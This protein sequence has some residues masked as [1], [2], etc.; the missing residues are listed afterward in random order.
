MAN[1][2]ER[3]YDL[4]RKVEQ[5]QHKQ[6]EYSNELFQIRKEIIQLKSTLN[7]S[8]TTEP[9]IDKPKVA[10]VEKEIEPIVEVTNHSR[11]QVV[12]TQAVRK[13][14]VISSN[15]PRKSSDLE[16]FIGENLI[17]KIGILIVVIGVAIG[18]KYSI[19]HKLISPL[20]RIVLGYGTG[21]AL[22]LVGM[23]L[24]KNYEKYS[25]VLVSGAMAIMYF[26]TYAAY[27]IYI[28]M[29]QTM[30]FVLMLVFTVF[31]VVAA[32]NYKQQVIAHLGLVG[33][34]AVPFLLSDGSGRV[35]VLFTYIVII[36]M[37][38]L[39]VSF[40]NYWRSLYYASF[41]LTW[42][43]FLSWYILKYDTNLHL[44]ITVFFTLTTFVTFYF[45]F[46]AYKLIQ[47]EK[48]V[49]RDII[50]LLMNA[51][52][53]F[54][55]GYHILSIHKNGGEL[56]GL[57]ALFNALIHFVVSII[58]YKQ[59]LADKNLFYLV[60]GLVLVFL[61]IAIPIQLDG[62][63]VTLLWSGEAALL[64]WIGRSK[65]VFLY[66][67]LSYPVMFLAFFS[68]IQD[69]NL[70]YGNTYM[71]NQ[72]GFVPLLNINFLS[73]I[74]FICAFS[75]IAYWLF[76]KV[77]EPKEDKSGIIEL[78]KIGIAS[79][80]LIVLFASF[81]LELSDYWNLRIV[82]SR[83]D[84]ILFKDLKSFKNI[85]LVN[86][87]LVF[88][89]LLSAV[90]IYRIKDKRLGGVNFGLNLLGIFLFL[91]VGLYE[92]SELRES[93]IAHANRSTFYLGV[94]YLSFLFA[95]GLVW[96]TSVYVK[97]FFDKKDL[98]TFFEIFM[99]V[100]IVWVISSE[101]LH[102]LDLSSTD[103]NYKLGLSIL[104]GVYS[105]MLIMI[106][107]WRNKKHLRIGAMVLF[108][109]TL[110][111]LFVYDLRHLNTISKTIVFV[112]LGVLLLIISFLYNK[113]SSRINYEEEK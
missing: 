88:F 49:I 54:S 7:S 9:N 60:G 20:T 109:I 59:K 72:T 92:Y 110:I 32:I 55:V 21:L 86:Y 63:W 25:A 58:I 93:F 70:A 36:N 18:V 76:V 19:E 53:F 30:A 17:S 39:F 87:T 2:Q 62:N 78:I 90:N 16:K 83:E 82:R 27:G 24:K 69:W 44:G 79:I 73:S 108:G 52:V 3:L 37:G 45:T 89:I 40:K 51:F 61:T 5:L 99:H 38:I 6:T 34:Y 77:V 113:Y 67:K 101:L 42:L 112:S 47:K 68:L 28:L 104:W 71:L 10:Q 111:K 15:T 12:V 74:L 91:I 41:I 48:Y 31:T 14:A 35:A 33:A 94:R 75:F 107:L 4:L 64:F 57:F 26:I 81:A 56:L 105:L 11:E 100:V 65:K 43:I 95:G 8:Q 85:W 84:F 98:R 46:L 66:E 50:L 103:K 13:G 1:E 22:L 29:P 97:R 23:K 96:I 102:W 106:G 80:L